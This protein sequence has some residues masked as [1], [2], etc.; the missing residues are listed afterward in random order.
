MR[1]SHFLLVLVIVLGLTGRAKADEDFRMVVLDPDYPTTPIFSTPFQFNFA[2]CVVGQ[3]PTNAE[4]TYDGCF[5]GVNR[6][7]SDWVGVE[8]TL[9]NTDIL[10]GQEA[11]CTD[12]GADIYQTTICSLNPDQAG[13]T[14]VYSIGNI[15]NNGTFVIAEGGVDPSLFPTIT[16]VAVTSAVPEPNTLIFLCTGFLC[17][18]VELIWKGKSGFRLASMSKWIS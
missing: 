15:P 6:T 3:L 14:L 7:G 9:S 4:G 16:F 8:M 18:F 11:S 12:G 1:I 10:G 5:S 13:Y 2:P 17:S